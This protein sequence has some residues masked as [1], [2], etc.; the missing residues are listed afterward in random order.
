LVSPITDFDESSLRDSLVIVV[1]SHSLIYQVFHALPPMTTPQGEPVGAVH[2][3][4]SDLIELR[5]RFKPKYLI[6]AFDASEETFRNE[7]YPEYKARREPMPDDLR[8]QLPKIHDAVPA[9]GAGRIE[10]PG[11]E[12][13]D[14]LATIAKQVADAGGRCLIVTSDKDCRQLIND[15]V[16][17]YNIRKNETFGAEQLMETWGIA[18][19]QVVDFQSLVGDPVDNV[20]GVPL[21]GPKL[22]AELLQ[23]YRTLENVL[24]HADEVAG[25]KRRQNLI[26]G[27]EQALL[28][29]QLV[30]LSNDVPC[31]IPWEQARGDDIDP[32]RIEFL[33]RE[34]GFRRLKDRATEV[35]GAARPK[36][37]TRVGMEEWQ[38][39]YR[40][41]T[42]P[43]ELRLLAD[44]C[45]A[46]N[47]IALHTET[48]HPTPT[49]GDLVGLSVAWEKGTAAYI[50]LRAPH[51][52]KCA[53]VEDFREILGPILEDSRIEKIGQNLKFDLNMLRGVGI[54]LRGLSLDTMVADYLL[55]PGQRN[56][57]L[58]DL[59]KRYLAHETIAID[60]LLGGRQQLP[61]DQV[62][63]E[64]VCDYAAERAD[65]PFRL[66]PSLEERLK[67]DGLFSLHRDVE[68]PLVEVLADLEYQG[69][70]VD[71]QRLDELSKR[72]GTEIDR[73]LQEIQSLAGGDLNPD[74]PKQLGVVLFQKLG[75][76]VV[77]R[78][79][80]GPS[81]DAE[82]L[83]TLAD[84]HPLPKLIL[85][86]R[87]L[88]KL[89][90]T[91]LDALPTLINPKTQRI[92]TS[93]RQDVA[94]TGRLSSSDPNLQNIPIRTE[95]GRA[96]RSA[97]LPG[98]PGWR[99]VAADY[100]QIELRVLAHF[101]EDPAL[102]DAYH[103]DQD[104][105]ARV[106][107][108]VFNVAESQVTS[109]MRRVAK[110][111]NFGIIYGQ[112]PYGLA[113]T[114]KISKEQAAQ[115]ILAYFARYPGVQRFMQETLAQCRR[116]GFVRTMLDRRRPVTGIRDFAQLS[117]ERKLVLTE[118]ERIAVNTVI[119]GSAADLIKIA[120]LRTHRAL[121]DAKLEAQML[122]QI[123]DELLFETSPSDQGELIALVRKEMTGAANLKVP[124]KVD[125]KTG[126]NWADCE[127]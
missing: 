96:I 26:D 18:P 55:E 38:A 47:R 119:Q 124:I 118:P 95:E 20:P 85:E 114:L 6:C 92:H 54:T 88:T 11:Y 51:G 28:S 5:Q 15:Q 40:L 34:W 106:A 8:I 46:V 103:Q 23:K 94:A 39:N 13:D 35:V 79:K 123:H 83:E 17:L 91:Y 81:T 1:D 45:H 14:L 101:C 87:Q 113:K 64:L 105:H 56:H 3:F 24:D 120:M 104:I 52:T 36:R 69:I 127:K 61:T 66:A 12:A 44:R 57:T 27:R 110:T 117:I 68:L 22:A 21:V 126:T 99:L 107:A 98:P 9:F 7:I 76:R 84:E 58:D 63:V 75:L 112:S 49:H 82:V 74:S 48:T 73:Y 25:P 116:D 108:E 67:R 33:C 50:P 31:T 62:P 10:A 19:E 80:S 16:Q 109:D 60:R 89:K 102:L 2:G 115:Y 78:T 30:R 53:S 86:Y 41:V 100:S 77:K 70:R 121:A 71:A 111:I 59:A 72:F 29:R 125:V 122:L 42:S 4:L 97:F 90:S 65:V 37:T 93:F 32:E 43:D